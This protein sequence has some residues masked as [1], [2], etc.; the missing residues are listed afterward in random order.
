M[1]AD[2]PKEIVIEPPPLPPDPVTEYQ[3][4]ALDAVLLAGADETLPLLRTSDR[5]PFEHQFF[6][7]GGRCY[8]VAV[9][10]NSEYGTTLEWTLGPTADGKTMSANGTRGMN[11]GRRPGRVVSRFC[12]DRSGPVML[13]TGGQLAPWGLFSLGMA[14]G[15]RVETIAQH[16]ARIR[17]LIAGLPE[18]QVEVVQ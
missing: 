16:D 5:R 4:Q 13:K 15:W 12:V 2:P 6:A 10:T 18:Y 1:A 17:R 8:F 7:Q 9:F 11:L 14:I 3:K